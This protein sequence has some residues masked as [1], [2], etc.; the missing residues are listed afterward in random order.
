GDGTFGPPAV[1]GVGRRPN[2]VLMGDLD[3]QAHLDVVVSNQSNDSVSVLLNR[4]F[5]PEIVTQPEVVVL[6]PAT[7]GVAELSVVATGP[8]LA[9]QW[10]RDGEPIADGG[11][12]SGTDSPTLNVDVTLEDVAAYDVV[13]TNSAGSVTSE[14]GV[15][16][17]QVV[18]RADLDGDGSLTLFDFLAFQNA[19]DAGCP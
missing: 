18:C 5:T 17:R 15:I 3:G 19:F 16:A 11:G 6:V 7:G 1:Y 12:V 8:D 9:Y 14:P 13:V 10:R 4:C 2:A